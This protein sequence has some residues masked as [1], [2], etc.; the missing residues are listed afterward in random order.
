MMKKLIAIT[1]CLALTLLACA[2][3][4]SNA[5]VSAPESTDSKGESSTDLSTMEQPGTS[6]PVTPM[7]SQ[8]AT[9]DA[10]STP[11]EPILP[12]EKETTLEKVLSFEIGENGLFS[13]HFMYP[14]EPAPEGITPPDPTVLVPEFHCIDEQGNLY[15]YHVVDGKPYVF[16]INDGNSVEL[17]VLGSIGSIEAYDGRLYVQLLNTKRQGFCEYSKEGFVKQYIYDGFDNS[18]TYLSFDSEGTPYFI[19]GENGLLSLDGTPFVLKNAP[20]I[21]RDDSTVM[22]YGSFSYPAEK[23]AW[24]C[25]DVLTMRYRCVYTQ[26]DLSENTLYRFFCGDD[27]DFSRTV[28]CEIT[29]GESV[30]KSYHPCIATV[31]NTTLEAMDFR[32]VE[33]WDRAMYLLAFYPDHADLY[34]INPGYT[35]EEFYDVITE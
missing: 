4:A 32:I 35:D 26:Y 20:E 29:D 21:S 27:I 31:G 5:T 25:G 13:Y 11:T 9:S 15:I 16:N 19:T 1:L 30:I 24:L 34:R 14:Q 8:P 22:T 23:N 17:K 10:V 33:A 6:A 28:D 7:S 2:C 12:E 18:E 3:A